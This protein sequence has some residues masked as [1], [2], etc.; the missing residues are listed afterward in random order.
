MYPQEDLDRS[1]VENLN[2]FAR[3]RGGDEVAW[4]ELYRACYPKVLRAVRRKMTSRAIRTIY[5]SADFA[6]DVWKSLAAKKD[7]YDFPNLEAL[8]AFLKQEAMRK[9]SDGVRRMHTL[10]RDIDRQ[11]PM[12]AMGDQEEA[13]FDPASADPTPSQVAQAVETHE[14]LLE[15]LA[16]EEREVIRLRNEGYSNEEIADRVGWHIRK[17]QRFLKDRLD[18]YLKE[19]LDTWFTSG[20]G[21][22]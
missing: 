13:H 11:R 5:D 17:V 14:Q 15:G 6:S 1:D 20:P 18:T 16:D 4:Q 2:L 9:V 21:A 7:R 8:V 22:N 12:G 10:K 3:A 19:R